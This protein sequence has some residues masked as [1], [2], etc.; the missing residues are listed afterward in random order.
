MCF[1]ANLLPRF[2]DITKATRTATRIVNTI[3]AKIAS[4]TAATTLARVPPLPRK[5]SSGA[6][7]ESGSTFVEVDEEKSVS[8]PT[9]DEIESVIIDSSVAGSATVVVDSSSTDSAVVVG[10]SR[11]VVG[12]P[13]AVDVVGGAVVAQGG[14]VGAIRGQS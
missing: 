11:S 10:S 12:S 9:V 3:R 5:I 13:V 1:T 14:G 6:C 4:T 8:D 7:V 2:L